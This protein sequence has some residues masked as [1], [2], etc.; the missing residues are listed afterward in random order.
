MGVTILISPADEV[1]FQALAA[2]CGV[3]IQSSML[4]IQLKRSQQ[5]QKVA[6]EVFVYHRHI[7]DTEVESYL[8]RPMDLTA[9]YDIDRYR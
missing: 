8:E 7:D 4:Y 5:H 2:Y 6:T 1:A 9:G 3:A